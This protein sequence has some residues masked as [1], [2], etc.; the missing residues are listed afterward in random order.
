MILWQIVLVTIPQIFE[1][2]YWSAGRKFGPEHK[3]DPM[4]FLKRTIE[5]RGANSP[6]TSKTPWSREVHGQEK[7]ALGL[8]SGG[9]YKLKH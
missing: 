6:N 7:V 5:A 2:D 3:Q 9:A 8:T 1:A 4:K